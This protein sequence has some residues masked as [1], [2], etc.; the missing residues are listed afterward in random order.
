[1]YKQIIAAISLIIAPLSLTAQTAE[2]YFHRGAQ[3]YVFGDKE[4]SKAE[5]VTGLGKYPTDPQLNQM[6]S[7]L[8]KEEQE[9]QQ[10]KGQQNKSDNDKQNQQKNSQDQQSQQDKSQSEQN[11]N[12]QANN[13]QD[14]KKPDQD[15][16]KENQ[17]QSEAKKQKEEE[18]KKKETAQN[19]ASGEQKD[20]SDEEAKREAAMM[21][22]GEMTPQQAQQ[23][24]DAEKDDEQVLRLA[25]PN[26]NTSQSRSFKNW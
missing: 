5:I 25:P 24:L 21:A 4:K 17:N 12:S 10:N 9:K 2:D 22:A 19:Q 8:K 14:E 6:A 13:K 3:F 26:K 18:E 20:K 1:V 23:L 15:Q 16:K 11:Q 7:L